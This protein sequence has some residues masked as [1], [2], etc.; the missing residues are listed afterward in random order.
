MWNSA[1]NYAQYGRNMISSYWC[2]YIYIYT[3]IHIYIYIHTYIY[4]QIWSNVQLMFH[5]KPCSFRPWQRA[6]NLQ[7]AL[8]RAEARYVHGRPWPRR[9]WVTDTLWKSNAAMEETWKAPLINKKKHVSLVER[10]V[11]VGKLQ[12]YKFVFMS[13][14]IVHRKQRITHGYFYGQSSIV[15]WDY[16]RVCNGMGNIWSVSQD[17]LPQGKWESWESCSRSAPR[18]DLDL[19][20]RWT[21]TWRVNGFHPK[22]WLHGFQSIA[23]FDDVHVI[24]IE[25]AVFNSLGRTTHCKLHVWF[26]H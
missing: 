6:Q 4:I 8:R 20:P 10:Q 18:I 17:E 16:Q 22:N 13:E 3:Y 26:A 14:N 23:M 11:F 7:G 1:I 19:N 2:V 9:S 12:V 25:L 15:R 21:S 24:P 5:P